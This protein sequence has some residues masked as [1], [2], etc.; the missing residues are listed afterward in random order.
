M[1][2]SLRGRFVEVDTAGTEETTGFSL[3]DVT[4]VDAGP[5]GPPGLEGATI[6]LDMP[7]AVAGENWSGKEVMV[8]GHFDDPSGKEENARRVLTVEH[9]E[10]A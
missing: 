6:S 1:A 9:I 2:V 8:E 3:E 5:D 4:V 7:S 10:E